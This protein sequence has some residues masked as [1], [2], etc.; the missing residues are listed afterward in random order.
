M[1][2]PV[3]YVLQHFA[4]ASRN[5]PVIPYPLCGHRHD[6]PTPLKDNLMQQQPTGQQFTMP[7]SFSKPPMNMNDRHHWRK[8]AQLTRLIREEVLVRARSM[9]LPKNCDTGVTVALHYQ[10]RDNR[11]RDPSNLIATQKPCL[12]ALV[13]YGLIPD[14]T[15]EFVNELMPVIH[16]AIKGEP[17]KCWLTIEVEKP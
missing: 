14:D 7:L 8:K 1:F 16:P 4:A 13:S 3:C 5:I 10:P 6:H 15:P 17:G 12:D 11:R 2:T 9:R